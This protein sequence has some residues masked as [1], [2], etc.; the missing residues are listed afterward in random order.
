MNRYWTISNGVL[1]KYNK[2]I[3]CAF[4]G[5]E[6]EPL[7]HA[8]ANRLVEEVIS[9]RGSRFLLVKNYNGAAMP[10]ADFTL[11]DRPSVC[12]TSHGP[13]TWIL[14]PS[15][16]KENGISCDLGFL[17]DGEIWSLFEVVGSCVMVSAQQ[18]LNDNLREVFGC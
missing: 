5:L 4:K 2:P 7:N 13:D 6:L 3:H 18:R 10:G 8:S 1:L 15:L 16:L 12:A 17:A 11:T 14:L 9:R